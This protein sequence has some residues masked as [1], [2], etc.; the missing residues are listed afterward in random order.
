MVNPE[1]VLTVVGTGIGIILAMGAIVIT[2][3]LW[4]RGEGNADRRAIQS[5][6]EGMKLEMRD[7]HDRLISIEEKRNR[8]IFKE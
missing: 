7:F 1:F 6:I 2:L 8:F 4:T 3:S 5:S